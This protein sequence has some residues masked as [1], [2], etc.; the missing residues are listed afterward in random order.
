MLS[1][2]STVPETAGGDVLSRAL[3]RFGH[4][5]L[6]PGQADVIADIFAGRPVISVMPTGA[7]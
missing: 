1:G 4:D 5:G 7:G 3:A 6:R 2:A